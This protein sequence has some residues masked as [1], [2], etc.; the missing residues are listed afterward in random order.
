MQLTDLVPEAELLKSYE[1][2]NKLSLKAFR[3]NNKDALSKLDSIPTMNPHVLRILAGDSLERTAL[4]LG[5]LKI[6]NNALAKSG[7]STWKS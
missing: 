1:E 4:I 7:A 3:E 2:L 5:F 6:V